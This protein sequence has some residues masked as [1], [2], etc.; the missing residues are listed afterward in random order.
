LGLGPHSVFIVLA[1]AAASIVVFGLI[2]WVVGD[3]R[4]QRRMLADLERQGV[5]RRSLR[6]K[7]D[8]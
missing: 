2:A 3:Y 4:M 8:A 6:A 1:Y 7:E 5:T